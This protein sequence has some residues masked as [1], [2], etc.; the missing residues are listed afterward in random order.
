[1]SSNTY[2]QDDQSLLRRLNAGSHA[3][4]AHLYAMYY[5][6]LCRL[7]A[8]YLQDEER[9]K[10]LVQQVFL[11]IW[12]THPSVR[13]TSNLKNYLY[14]LV[15][16]ASLNLLRDTPDI[17]VRADTLTD[18]QLDNIADNT[19]QERLELNARYAR[20][21]KAVGQLPPPK[22]DVFLLKIHQRL[23]NREIAARLHIS[24][25]TVKNYYKLSVRLLRNH[26]KAAGPGQA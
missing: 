10:D 9:A 25:S 17:F 19:A 6:P 15:K 11:R 16:N 4:F 18:G 2:P 14:T 5:P 23:S 7:S 22:R 8:T 20:F 12:E 13:V 1:M 26:F 24:E 21:R 3:A